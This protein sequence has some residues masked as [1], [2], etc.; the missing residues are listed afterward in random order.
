MSRFDVDDLVSTFKGQAIGQEAMDLAL[1]QVSSITRLLTFRRRSSPFAHTSLSLFIQKQ[2]AQSLRPYS[3]SSSSSTSGAA[4]PS[5]IQTSSFHQQYATY[6]AAAAPSSYTAAMNTPTS[7]STSAFWA[8]ASAS[9]SNYLP[10]GAS[11]PVGRSRSASRTRT[12]TPRVSRSNSVASGNAY[13]NSDWDEMQ[14]VE[15]ELDQMDDSSYEQQWQIQ[16]QQQ[17]Q[18]YYEQQQQQYAQAHRYRS[19]YP[20]ASSNQFQQQQQAPSSSSFASSDPFYIA[21]AAASTQQPLA[22]PTS[23]STASKNWFA[24]PVGFA[25]YA[26]AAGSRWVHH[27]A[28]QVSAS[29]AQ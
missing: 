15:E 19:A 18:A 12:T 10:A 13:D 14:E 29:A 27:H 4:F 9:G 22:Q 16:Q 23:S 1:L 21:T 25:A 20:S 24:P 6:G 28:A 5:P 17:Q 7:A 8:S 3:A 11:S 2:L 26:P